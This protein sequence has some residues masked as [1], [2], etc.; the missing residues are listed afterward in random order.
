MLKSL[1]DGGI[2]MACPHM[3]V[4]RPSVFANVRIFILAFLHRFYGGVLIR[5]G[6]LKWRNVLRYFLAHLFLL[7][8][9][10]EI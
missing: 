1:G 2:L 6:V 4:V 8:N 3:D 7:L 5:T 9:K 10:K